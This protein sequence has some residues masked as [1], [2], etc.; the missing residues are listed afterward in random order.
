MQPFLA[1]NKNLNRHACGKSFVT[2]SNQFTAGLAQD[3]LSDLDTVASFAAVG[4]HSKTMLTD[5]ADFSSQI[6]HAHFLGFGGGQCLAGLE[7]LEN[8]ER[9][10]FRIDKFHSITF[11]K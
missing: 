9:L 8:T 2:Q 1:R 11:L 7:G 5:A 4:V 6:A 3:V 10:G